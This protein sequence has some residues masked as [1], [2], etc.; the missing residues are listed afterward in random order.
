MAKK[1]KKKKKPPELPGRPTD[2]RIDHAEMA[3]KLCLLGATDVQLAEFFNVSTATINNWKK[4]HPKFLESIKRGKI[5]A[6][7]EMAEA[8]YK[9]GIGYEHPDVHI[10]N[11]QGEITITEL[12]KHYPPDTAAAFIWLKN[13]AG[14]Q[15]KKEVE[16]TRKELTDEEI[17]NVRNYL[18][19]KF[20]KSEVVQQ[21][22]DTMVRTKTDKV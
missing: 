15:D 11:Y 13:R 10:S 7:A 12:T 21:T 8:L 6:D 18:K 22:A 5:I 19:R 1:Y 4:I 17:E 14:W 16:V 20:I 3:Y 9:R 2:Y